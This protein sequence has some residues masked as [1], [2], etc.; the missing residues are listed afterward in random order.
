MSICTH[1][2]S[3]TEDFWP[4][5]ELEF[6]SMCP[7]CS[8][9]RR[10]LVHCNLRDRVFHCAP[11]LWSLWECMDCKCAYLNPRPTRETISRA[12]LCYFTHG[13]DLPDAHVGRIKNMWRQIRAAYDQAQNPWISSNTGSA[14]MHCLMRLV[15]PIFREQWKVRSRVY[16][17]SPGRRLLD[18]GCGN[19]DYLRNASELGW[20]A[21]GIDPDPEAVALAASKALQVRCSDLDTEAHLSPLAYDAITISH[22]IEHFHDPIAALRA[23]WTLLRPGGILWLSTPR[24]RSMGYQH[25]QEN[26]VHLD[27]PRHLVLFTENNIHNALAQVNFTDIKLHPP[28]RVNSYVWKVSSALQQNISDPLRHPAPLLLRESLQAFWEDAKSLWFPTA[29]EQLIVTAKKNEAGNG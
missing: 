26:W 22:A 8:S 19:G 15:A 6:T 10:C 7:L 25:F 16:P 13:D 5:E 18:V 27:P 4:N 11:G 12:Y 17:P 20:D 23:C 21:H 9:K 24:W 2:P 28:G 1:I 3:T 29:G 14:S